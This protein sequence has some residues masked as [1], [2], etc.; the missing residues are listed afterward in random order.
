M[1]SAFLLSAGENQIQWGDFL[2]Y[3]ITFIVLIWL[4]KYF[5]WD[6]VAGMMDKRATKIANDIDSASN[7]R[8]KAAELAKKREAA[9]KDSRAEASQIVD[10]AKKNGEDQKAT[11]INDANEEAAA[12]RDRA[13]KDIAQQKE[14]ALEGVKDDVA[15][16]SIEIASKVIQKELNPSNHKDLVDS[17]IEGLGKHNENR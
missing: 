5:A 14:E 10:Q 11:I 3:L 12:M 13:Q 6:S 8:K 17:D 9:L 15:E 4:V 7:D 1:I 2:F 16:L